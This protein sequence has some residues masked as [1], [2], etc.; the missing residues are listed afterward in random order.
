MTF[1]SRLRSVVLWTLE[2]L[3][4]TTWVATLWQ[5]TDE[6]SSAEVFQA[7]LVVVLLV[8]LYFAEGIELAVADLLDKQPEQI[9]DETVRN[10]LAEIQQQRGFFFSQRQIF[11]VTIIAFMTLMVSYEWIYIPGFG[12]NYELTFWFSFIFTTLTVLWFCQV[13]PKRLAVINSEQFLSQ[14]LFLWPA[15]KLLGRLGLPEP[16]EDIVRFMEEHSAYRRKRHLRPSRTAHYDTMTHLYGFSLDRLSV[17]ISIRDDGSA[18]IQQK[19]MVVFTRGEHTRVYGNLRTQSSF[20]VPPMMKP[21]ALFK[22]ATPEQFDSIASDLDAI[23][24]G[25]APERDNGFSDNLIDHFAYDIEVTNHANGY[26]N[27][28][29]AAW[30][31][32]LRDPLPESLWSPTDSDD[33]DHPFVALLYSVEA[34]VSPGAFCVPGTDHW[35]EYIQFPCRDLTVAIRGMPDAELAVRFV[36]CEVSLHNLTTTLPEET[37]RFNGFLRESIASGQNAIRMPFPMQGGIYRI[38]WQAAM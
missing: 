33:G 10:V 30:T 4:V 18:I 12:K 37:A 3:L 38:H 31:I 7:L 24:D 32:K 28:Q 6:G 8:V 15:I 35:D 36:E 34:Q 17:D 21:L 25:L 13:T 23:F 2:A 14:S 5:H 9:R 16:S 11:V 27:A 22:R 26:R 1:F 20:V 19:L 29:E